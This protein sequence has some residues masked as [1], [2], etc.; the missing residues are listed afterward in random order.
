MKKKLN[1]LFLCSWYPSRV[2]P[3]NAIFVQ[4]HAEAANSINNVSVVHIISDA[5]NVK[6][7][8]YSF[9][10][11]NGLQTYIAYLKPTKNKITKVFRYFKAYKELRKLVRNID[12]IHVNHGFPLGLFAIMENLTSRIPFVSSEHWSGY[13]APLNEKI[14][15]FQKKAL[16]IIFK[17]ASFICPVSENLKDSMIEFGLNAKYKC[18]PNVVDTKLFTPN[19][20]LS[21]S[22]QFEITHIS[23]M[24]NEIKN[25]QGILNVISRLEKKIPNIKF[26]LIGNNNHSYTQQIEE[27]NIKCINITNFLN[28]E[29]VAEFLRKS[30]VFVLFSNYENLP[31]VILESF[32]CG[33]PVISTNVGGIKEYFPKEFGRL[34]SPKDELAL[35]NELLNY[36]EQDKTI[37]K[38]KMHSYCK[39]NFSF[40]T[41]GK[42]F[43]EIY[44]QT[45]SK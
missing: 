41:I 42:K 17:R 18:V 23:N 2:H 6:N 31:C 37:P 14:N 30:D 40:Y 38:E 19:L 33:T 25:V 36:Y 24:V 45:L 9:S 34:I 11:T 43:S 28:P 7:I 35:E 22:S 39:D 3:E 8:E 1:I 10:K 4:R 20:N 5:N 27:L 13:K 15:F 12:V 21:N 16:K 26:N 29:E 32:S 44:H